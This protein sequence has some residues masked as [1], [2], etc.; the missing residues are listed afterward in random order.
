[1]YK[2]MVNLTKEG[3]ACLVISSD[4]SEILG[5]SDRIYVM[6]QGKIVDELACGSENIY[7]RLI[8]SSL[9]IQ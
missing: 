7:E 9:G 6:R 1:M 2:I 8:E 4:I 5:L 3:A